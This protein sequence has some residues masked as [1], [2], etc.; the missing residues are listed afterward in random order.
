M[1]LFFDLF[2]RNALA[3]VQAPLGFLQGGKELYRRANLRQRSVDRQPLNGVHDEFFVAHGANRS[4]RLL[5]WQVMPSCECRRSRRR[6]QCPSVRSE[7]RRVGKECR[8]RWA[9]YD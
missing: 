3:P 9:T 1:E 4:V 2:M 7:E 8:A 5:T 6:R